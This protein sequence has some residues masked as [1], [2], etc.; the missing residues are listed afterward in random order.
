MLN[1]TD[2]NP[3]NIWPGIITSKLQT[4]FRLQLN[5][6]PDT[7]NYFLNWA[8]SGINIAPDPGNHV[9]FCP[10]QV[11]CNQC[12]CLH[13]SVARHFRLGTV[14]A[15]PSDGG[16]GG[17]F[18]PPSVALTTGLPSATFTYTPASYGAKT[19]SVVNSGSLVNPA[20]LTFTCVAA[21]Y[22]L[23]GP[24]SGS[25]GVPST[26]FTVALPVGSAVLGSVTVTPN[27]SG[28]GGTFTPASVALT[29][30][31]PSATFTYTPV[32]SGTKT[33]ATTNNG[34][35]T[36]PASL[37]Y[38]ATGGCS[39]TFT[40]T[41][42]TAWPSHTMDV[43]TGW[44][45]FEGGGTNQSTISPTNCPAFNSGNAYAYYTEFSC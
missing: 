19:I 26:N 40:D 11:W 41:N 21:T 4:G 30:G 37:S 14:T 16:G 36:N 12:A 23:S 28:A 32:S 7:G 44:T 25:S 3:L 1:T 42:G 5:G 38:T 10:V 8:I 34:G 9:P 20:N 29:T 35:L 27:D 15:T 18:S 2:S 43:G 17:A 6:L 13:R 22:T 45:R 39:D 31:A 33:I 24:S